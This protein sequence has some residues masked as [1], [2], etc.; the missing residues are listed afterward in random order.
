[1]GW[2]WPGLSL[3]AAANERFATGAAELLLADRPE[4]APRLYTA[5]A[6]WANGNCRPLQ[7][8]A[9]TSYELHYTKLSEY[10]EAGPQEP[11]NNI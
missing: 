2:L 5:T 6:G 1:M 3:K 10:A 8:S 7:D 11:H 4:G 9:L